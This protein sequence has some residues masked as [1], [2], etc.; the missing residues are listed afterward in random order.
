MVDNFLPLQIF[1][2]SN[3]FRE[4]KEIFDRKHSPLSCH[5]AFAL[6]ILLEK[7]IFLLEGKSG[8]KMGGNFVKF[9]FNYF[10]KLKEKLRPFLPIELI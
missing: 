5:L 9:N 1:T 7:N 2:M 4:V 8:T 3:I 10:N 6:N